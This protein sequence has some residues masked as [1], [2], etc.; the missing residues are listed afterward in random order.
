[1]LESFAPCSFVCLRFVGE[2]DFF[3]F[4][5]VLFCLQGRGSKI[6]RKSQRT[7]VAF[8]EGKMVLWDPQVGH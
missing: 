1:M 2:K 3:V 8:R 5:C 4:F 6:Q 7:Q